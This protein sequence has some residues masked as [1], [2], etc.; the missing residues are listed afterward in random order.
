M[1][2]DEGQ[3]GKLY[4]LMVTL[5]EIE[6]PIWRR[7]LVPSDISLPRLH[8]VLQVAMGWHDCHLHIFEIAG[9]SY[10]QIDP[11][12]PWSME[13]LDERKF[14][15]SEIV[16]RKGAAFGYTYD[17]DDDWLHEI[18]LEAILEPTPGA[19]YPT[20]IEGER[21]GPPEDCGG[22]WG[23]EELLV[24]LSGS[25]DPDHE[26]LRDWVGGSFDP[27]AFGLDEVNRRLG[28]LG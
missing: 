28:A 26:E 9:K 16:R 17:M 25:D 18:R 8:D 19:S 3:S 22:P 2:G 1:P 14:T 4:Q 20:C 27:E 23:Y 5:A 12:D 13:M 7:L 24:A 6:P 15:L 10:G 21:S 11:E